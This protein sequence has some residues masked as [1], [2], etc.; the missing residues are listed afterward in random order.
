MCYD[1]AKR[2][3]VCG[4]DA[5][6][7]ITK[8]YIYVYICI[9]KSKYI[10]AY[11][12]IYMYTCIYVYI[13]LYI[14]IY[15][16]RMCGTDP[17]TLITK[18][19][20]KVYIYLYKSIYTITYIYRMRGNVMC[21]LITKEYIYVYIC[22]YKSIYTYIYM[23]IVIVA[24][25]RARSSL[26]TSPI[27]RGCCCKL[28]ALTTNTSHKISVGP[29]WGGDW[30]VGGCACVY[31]RVWRGRE[32]ERVGGLGARFAEEHIAEDFVVWV[33]GWLGG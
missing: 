2:N 25:T 14:H 6:S 17:C 12:S 24:L 3:L 11:I 32:R 23:Y 22:I 16:Y 9:Y 30:W 13:N 4:T 33:G 20:I 1:S 7:L 27:S 5:C 19:Q 28:H 26:R 8:V 15:I 31:V 10:Y 29:T 18:I 21:A